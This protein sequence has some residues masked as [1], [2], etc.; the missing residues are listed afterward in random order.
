ME[1]IVVELGKQVNGRFRTNMDG[2][3]NERHSNTLR[4]IYDNSLEGMI[5]KYS[6]LVDIIVEAYYGTYHKYVEK[7]DLYS[8]AYLALVQAYDD[9]VFESGKHSNPSEILQSRLKAAVYDY[10]MREYRYVSAKC[11][12]NV[13]IYCDEDTLMRN[14]V[15]VLLRDFLNTMPEK[16]RRILDMYYLQGMK[17]REIADTIGV[18]TS[19][20]NVLLNEALWRSRRYVRSRKIID[21]LD[22]YE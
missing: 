10:C 4:G 15:P 2:M 8:Q 19:M 11:E 22:L 21:L 3:V 12:G 17:L 13:E 20:T 5:G 9:G 7:C 1:Q 14:I 16:D 18:G 6:Y